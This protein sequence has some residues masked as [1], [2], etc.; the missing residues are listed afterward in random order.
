MTCDHARFNASVSVTR[1]TSEEGGPVIGFTADLTIQCALCEKPFQFEGME[2]GVSR[3]GPRCSFDGTEARL[4]LTP[5]DE[6]TFRLALRPA[7]GAA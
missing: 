6:V 3:A 2:R 5:F 1:L 7:E 4:P